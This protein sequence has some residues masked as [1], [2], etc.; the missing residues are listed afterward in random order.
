MILSQKVMLGFSVIF[1]MLLFV[2]LSSCSSDV[3]EQ[4]GQV[5]TD[6]V[7]VDSVESMSEVKL[8]NEWFI[9]RYS[10]ESSNKWLP[11]NSMAKPSF[12]MYELSKFPNVDATETQQLVA[13]DMIQK[14]KETAI[15]KGWLDFEKAQQD[16]FTNM[17]KD[18][19]HFVNRSFLYDGEIANPDKP[20]FLMFYETQ[21]G[22]MLMGVMFAV[23]QHGPQFGGPLTVWHYHVEQQ[24][25]YE[26]GIL[27]IAQYNEN[28]ECEKGVPKGKSPEMLHLW[29]FEHPEGR[30]AT[31]M[32]L[33]KKQF[34]QAVLEVSAMYRELGFLD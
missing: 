18:R 34:D 12:G 17:Y 32:R 30:F 4:V 7:V 5:S 33:T 28:G 26:K 24:I 11:L 23:E 14:T 27:P 10:V 16:G 22:P 31:R 19:I 9:R 8:S 2:F 21:Y 3:A 20:E 15:K 25:C 1:F 13:N 6:T 29:F